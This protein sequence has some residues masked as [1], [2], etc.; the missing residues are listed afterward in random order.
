M[1][2]SLFKAIAV[3]AMVSVVWMF[4]WVTHLEKKISELSERV[5][6]LERRLGNDWE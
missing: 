6:Q 4:F 5:F 1:D 2:P 3:S